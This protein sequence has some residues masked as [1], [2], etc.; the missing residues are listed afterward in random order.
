MPSNSRSNSESPWGLVFALA[1]KEWRKGAQILIVTMIIALISYLSFVPFVSQS[2]VLIND[3]QNSHLQAFSSSF[4][5]LSKVNGG[6]KSKSPSG[7]AKEYLK[8]QDTFLLFSQSLGKKS[9]ETQ[10]DLETRLALKEIQD[11]LGI[12]W[13]TEDLSWIEIAAA[14]KITTIVNDRTS[15]EVTL[16]TKANTRAAA[17]AINK[18]FSK[19]V[20]S[21]LKE[22]EKREIAKV[23]FAIQQQRDHFK[24]Q[25]E[26]KNKELIAFQSKPENVLSLASGSNVNNYIADL[27]VRKN[28]VELN[29]SERER[30]LQMMGGKKAARLARDRNLGQ[31]SE[32]QQLLD[33]ISLLR[34]QAS[35]LQSSIRKFSSA[36][37]GTAEAIR[38]HEELKKTTDREF[39]NF[40]EANDLLAKIGIYSVSVEG[41][42]ELLQAS[43]LSDVKKAISLYLVISLAF[44]LSQALFCAWIFWCWQLVEN[45]FPPITLVRSSTAGGSR[46]A[47]EFL[48]PKDREP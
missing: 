32:A 23:S 36:T 29:I 47:K 5:S 10:T 22:Q 17:H 1:L 42:F 12:N 15:S 21:A 19:F 46:F 39:K 2:V 45:K 40:Q 31:R 26:Q 27:V 41:K 24:T 6:K 14:L 13:K 7:L 28:E 9:K 20:L 8:R 16:I 25:F 33:Q 48:S 43:Q 18:E 3:A 34:K 30:A 37:N 35:A 44:F 38:M 11:Y 4:F